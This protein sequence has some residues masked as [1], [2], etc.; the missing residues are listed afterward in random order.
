MK[1]IK[2]ILFL[3]VL[4][5][6]VC[7]TGCKVTNDYIFDDIS[8]QR[9]TDYIEACNEVL[10]EAPHGWKLVYY[11]DTTQYGAYTFLMK[12]KEDNRVDMR[13]DGNDDATESSYSFNSSQ[14]PVLNFDTYSLLHRLADPDPNVAGGK[15]GIGY[16]GEFEFV[17]REVAPTKD[18]IYFLTKKEK[19]PVAFT[20]AKQED[21]DRLDECYTMAN[22]FEVNYDAPFYHYLQ[23]GDKVAF[24]FYSQKLRMAY[25]A[26]EE[27]AG[28]TVALKLPWA[29]TPDGIRLS[30]PV[31]FAGVTFSELTIGSDL[32]LRLLNASQEGA[33]FRAAEYTDKCL[34]RFPGSVEASKKVDGFNLVEYG[35]GMSQ[36]ID[37]AVRHN[38]HDYRFYWNLSGQAAGEVYLKA[39]GGMA[40]YA[41][42][43]V[44]DIVDDGVGDQVVFSIA[45][46]AGRTVIDG[47]VNNT[48]NMWFGGYYRYDL[49]NK[50][51]MGRHFLDEGGFT[52]IDFGEQMIMVRNGNNMAWALYSKK[53][54]LD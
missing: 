53:E 23:I 30:K 40:K 12:F 8:T 49:I 10:G 29:L 9:I 18:T 31:T 2:K 47:A 50:G 26:Y 28:R 42:L 43:Y 25:I 3:G 13:W 11:P 22:R 17:I 5:S 46:A 32:K 52:V 33:F 34:L 39:A 1:S 6:A 45:D 20:H 24:L 15:A 21:W 36:M 54:G 35:R 4:V 51:A 7:M 16:K 44:S 41:G 19:I 14:G 38:S 37:E 27:G 48:D